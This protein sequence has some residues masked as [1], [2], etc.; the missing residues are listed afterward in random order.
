MSQYLELVGAETV[1]NA[2]GT[3]AGAAEI[4]RQSASAI[5][6][7]LRNHE[8]FLDSWLEQF[9]EIIET[10]GEHPCQPTTS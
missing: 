10:K 6:E 7:S 4:M 3:I 5:D 1:Q 8:R 2:A 9:G